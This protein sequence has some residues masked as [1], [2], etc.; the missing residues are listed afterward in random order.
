MNNFIEKINLYPK[1]GTLKV[2]KNPKL[3]SVYISFGLIFCILF[4]LPV[5][6]ESFLILKNK[7]IFNSIISTIFPLISIFI[8]LF[9]P[10]RLGFWFG[11]FIG[12]G[13]FYWIALSFRYSPTPFLIPF[14]ILSLGIIY[15]IIIYY[16][17]FFENKFFRIIT[18]LALNYIHPFGFDWFFIQSFF[19]YG[20]FGLT[21]LDLFLITLGV[22]GLIYFKRF[23][24]I[25]GIFLLC[26]ALDLKHINEK[27]N[28]PFSVDISSTDIPQDIKWDQKTFENIVKQNFSIIYQAIKE[29]KDLVILPETS[30][31][32][33]LNKNLILLHELET[34]SHE[35]YIVTGAF[36]EEN[37]HIYNSAYY[38]KNG[39]YFYSDKVILAPFGEKIPLPDFLANP[40]YKIFFGQNYGLFEGKKFGDF[41]IGN[42]KLQSAICYEGTSRQTYKNNPQYLVLISNNAWFIPSIEPFFQRLLIKYYARIHHTT[43]LHSINGTNS[44]IISPGIFGDINL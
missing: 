20:F 5:Y 23:F 2:F 33:I 38:F 19:S 42:T 6:L 3:L 26:L 9:I 35:I 7:M 32:T 25:F 30:F 21:K 29:K 4:I 40:L 18:L 27:I 10:K 41:L 15:G 8:W 14:I 11:F 1:Y 44:Y 36:R 13:L 12:I 28:L 39:E 24:K 31:P 37:N 17:L 34:L 22:L 16:L 43:I